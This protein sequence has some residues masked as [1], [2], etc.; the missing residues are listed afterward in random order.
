M[1]ER[2]YQGTIGTLLIVSSVAFYN[3]YKKDDILKEPQKVTLDMNKSIDLRGLKPTNQNI[4]YKDLLSKQQKA[5]ESKNM[6][7]SSKLSELNSSTQASINMIKAYNLKNR[8][9]QLAISEADLDTLSTKPFEFKELQTNL[10]IDQIKEKIQNMDDMLTNDN[11]IDNY[12]DD[13]SSIKSSNDKT[14][15]RSYVSQSTSSA[16]SSSSTSG[17]SNSSQSVVTPTTPT[18]STIPSNDEPVDSD[19]PKY[20]AS[21]S[22]ITNVIEQINE[23]LK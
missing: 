23:N 9:T 12:L 10:D 22:D 14:T 19:I 13:D 15:Y 1:K 6:R 3:L 4:D 17:G 20:R 5:Y 18:T 21:I 8:N 11:S 7:L 16:T 2:I